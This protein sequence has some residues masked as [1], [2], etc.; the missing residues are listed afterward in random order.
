MKEMKTIIGKLIKPMRFMS[1]MVACLYFSLL[2]LS[3]FTFT[4]CSSETEEPEVKGT[5]VQIM[6]YMAPYEDVESAGTRAGEWTAPEGYY[7]PIKHS[8][9]GAFFTYSNVDKRHIWFNTAT[10]KWIIDKEATGGEQYL[11]GFSPNEAAGSSSIAPNSSYANGAVLTLNNMGSVSGEDICILVG[12]KE[13]TNEVTVEGLQVGKFKVTMHTSGE[14]KGNFLFMLFEHLYAAIDFQ[15]HVDD[16]YAAL[17]KIKLKKLELRGYFSYNSDDD[18][19]LMKRKGINATV[20]LQSNSTGESPIT[21]ITFSQNDTGDPM[22]FITFFDGEVEIPSGTATNSEELRYTDNVDYAY[23][24]PNIN[25]FYMLRSTYDVYDRD[26]HLIRVNSI[27]ENKI[28]MYKLF[29]SIPYLDRGKKYTIKLTLKP[30][31]LYQLGNWDLDN[32]TVELN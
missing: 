17:R 4:S 16:T 18:N 9:I 13:G 21:N 2:T 10:N 6:S 1:L 28:D 25:N 3:L 19:T 23:V 8:S 5:P 12:A 22:P 27:V 24:V 7:E 30:T 15:F 11:Y 26:D 29:N 32:P 31:Y 14:N 20:T